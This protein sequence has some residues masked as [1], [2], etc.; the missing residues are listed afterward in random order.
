MVLIH[1]WQSDQY[2]AWAYLGP[3]LAGSGRCVYSFTYGG[4]G[5]QAGGMA[6]LQASAAEVRA[7]IEALTARLGVDKVDVVGHS[8]GGVLAQYLA[9]TEPGFASHVRRLVAVSAPTHG[10][11][12]WGL[13]GLVR[14][15]GVEAAV[16]SVC[17]AAC[18][19]LL[20]TS[21]F[22]RRLTSGPIAVP[23][24]GYTT[25]STERD[26]LVTPSASSVI[27]EPGVRNLRLQDFCPASVAGHNGIV[28]SATT[29]DLVLGALDDALPRTVRCEAEFP[30]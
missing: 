17:G 30:F 26:E 19:D 18:P 27:A 4:R 5:K 6:P 15:Q 29:A 21:R 23:G 9:R 10:T 2:A 16:A 24:V 25:I 1:G 20:V 28:F 13:A 12:A 3:L 22:V 11:T 8:E 14:H 7:R